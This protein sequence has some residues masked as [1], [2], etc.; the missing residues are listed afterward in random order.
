LLASCAMH[1]GPQTLGDVKGGLE[2]ISFKED[3]LWDDV[4]KKFGDP[5]IAS[6]PEPG[7][8]LGKNSRVYKNSVV[9]FYVD[10]REVNMEGKTRFKEVVKM[11]EVCTKK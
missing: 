7:S 10:A 9:I 2:C 4:F 5:N 8:D 11:V 3:I 6:L 1:Q